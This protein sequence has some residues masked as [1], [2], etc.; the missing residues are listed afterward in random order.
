MERPSY[1]LGLTASALGLRP[2]DVRSLVLVSTTVSTRSRLSTKG[3]PLDW[4]MGQIWPV[5]ARS[6][7]CLT[8]SPRSTSHIG[9]AESET[10][11]DLGL[12]SGSTSAW[13]H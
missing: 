12:A 5:M 8:I 11:P 1:G 9:L 2:D 4:P 13:S 10:R 7:P 3:N 6:G